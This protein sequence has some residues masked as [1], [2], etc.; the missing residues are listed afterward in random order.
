MTQIP[1]PS[2]EAPDWR[3]LRAE[4][5]VVIPIENRRKMDLPLAAAKLSLIRLLR[6][7]LADAD[8]RDRKSVV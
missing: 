5:K 2:E 4:P 3:K 8:S 7:S 1:D 6:D